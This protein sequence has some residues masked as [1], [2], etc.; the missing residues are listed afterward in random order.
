MDCS[1][2]T[3]V[4][5]HIME[6]I[7]SYESGSES[8]TEDQDVGA[9]DIKRPCV[10][11]KTASD[12][13]IAP[14]Q[15]PSVGYVSKRKQRK[16]IQEYKSKGLTLES[17]ET[18]GDNVKQLSSYLK[19][20]SA[21]QQSSSSNHISRGVACRLCGHT[22]PVLSLDWHPTNDRLLLSASFDSSIIVWDHTQQQP[23][24]RLHTHSAAVR[25]CQW[26]SS[27][28]IVSGGYDQVAIYTDMH[29]QTPVHSFTHDAVVSALALNPT[30][31][32]I[33][34][35]GSS[36]KR[37]Q[38]WDLR[39]HKSV[40]TYTGAGGQILD[41]EL[42]NNGK[43]I[44][45]SSDIVRKNAAS[46]MMLV[47]ETSSTIVRS[48]QIYTEPFTCPSLHAHPWDRTFLAQ[49]NGDYVVIFSTDKPYK[50]NKYKRFEGHSVHG[51]SL[52]FS[53]SPD[54]S[55]VCSGSA[56][57][58]LFFYNYSSAKLIKRIKV[59]SAPTVAVSWHPMLPSTVACSSW[60][61]TTYIIQ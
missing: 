28:H 51:N 5:P 60:D 18:E 55:L 9:P 25:A 45:A 50:L 30:D 59:S 8:E 31:P 3:G 39:T 29:T 48:N 46:Q 43:E 19:E 57:G 20:N 10:R 15:S 32:N 44:V 21:I 42:L 34:F 4:W 23:V 2:G 40:N 16:Q 37:V 61:G 38:S 52:Q 56:C 13:D 1:L 36:A 27:T 22:K 17:N 47:W 49:S 58:S 53:I 35:T 24:S 33:F 12:H 14:H 41:L 26:M 7:A 11:V 54:G 6:S